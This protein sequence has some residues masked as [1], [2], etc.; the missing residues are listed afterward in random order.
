MKV[1]MRSFRENGPLVVDFTGGN[2]VS[3]KASSDEIFAGTRAE[4]GAG[5][6]SAPG[7]PPQLDP[8]IMEVERLIGTLRAAIQNLVD[9]TG[10]NSALVE[11]LRNL[12]GV[13]TNLRA[14]TAANGP[15]NGAISSVQEELR[16]VRNITD[17]IGNE[18]RLKKTVTN[19]EETTNRLK[20]LTARTD[21]SLANAL[22]QINSILGDVKQL[23]GK[24]KE[25]PWRILYPTTIKYPT[26]A[27]PDRPRR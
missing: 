23:T 22:P 4:V 13:I 5:E 8:A 26:P 2:P 3:G 15:I 6:R 24:L 16:S 21:R 19:L 17:Q 10:P 20:E 1:T 25:Q 11:V 27:Q 7:T 9:F 14:T 18:D 12:D